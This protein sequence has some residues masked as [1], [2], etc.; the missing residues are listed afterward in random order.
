MPNSFGPLDGFS[1][2]WQV[3]KALKPCKIVACRESISYNYMKENFK[4]I[5]FILT[6]DLG[7]YLQ[8]S[9]EVEFPIGQKEKGG[10]YR[11]PVSLSR[12]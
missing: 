2:K 4:D 3:R 11:P 9:S 6:D 12:T 1:V 7:F 8:P 10:Y 5:D